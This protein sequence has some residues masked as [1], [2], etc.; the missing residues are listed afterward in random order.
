MW[1]GLVDILGNP[2][3]GQPHMW[4]LATVN[5]SW[6]HQAASAFFMSVIF[7]K[8]TVFIVCPYKMF[9]SAFV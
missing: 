5:T 2:G 1:L 6:F 9:T 4:K 8:V 3:K 7:S